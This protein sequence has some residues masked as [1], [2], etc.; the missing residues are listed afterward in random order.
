MYIME[1]GRLN[2]PCLKPG[3]E[4]GTCFKAAKFLVWQRDYAC[5]IST[6]MS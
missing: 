6:L 5:V 2:I 1:W 3:L 4:D